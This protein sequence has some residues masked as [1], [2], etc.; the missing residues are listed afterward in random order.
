M[1]TEKREQSTAA[2]PNPTAARR[3]GAHGTPGDKRWAQRHGH[4]GLDVK[5][6]RAV[7]TGRLTLARGTLAGHTQPP[8]ARN[9][10][11]GLPH[12]D[13]GTHHGVRQRS[14]NC[15]WAHRHAALPLISRPL[16]VVRRLP[17]RRQ[18]HRRDTCARHARH[19]CASHT[20]PFPLLPLGMQGSEDA[21]RVPK[22][23]HAAHLHAICSV[24]RLN[25]LSLIPIQL[26]FSWF[27]VSKI[28]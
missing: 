18:F 6:W 26:T 2:K 24:G 27:L 3:T 15:T 10:P 22:P 7:A 16:A 1:P 11:H 21:G 17:S 19:R 25:S 12:A 14:Q 20:P 23:T 9:G 4:R 13:R 28:V 5:G 8:I